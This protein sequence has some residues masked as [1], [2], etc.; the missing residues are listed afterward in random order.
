MAKRSYADFAPTHWL[1]V[2]ERGRELRFPHEPSNLPTLTIWAA[3]GF[4]WTRTRNSESCPA[5]VAPF[6]AVCPRGAGWKLVESDSDQ[7]SGWRRRVS[8]AERERRRGLK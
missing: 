6:V 4:E 8:R 5:S 7:W 1:H 2:D 3:N